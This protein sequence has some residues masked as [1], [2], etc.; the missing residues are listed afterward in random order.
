MRVG[1]DQ[2]HRRLA[3]STLE[4]SLTGI[5]KPLYTVIINRL[6][7]QYHCKLSDCIDHPEYLNEILQ[8]LYGNARKAIVDSINKELS[9]ATEDREVERFLTV[10]NN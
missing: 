1:K 10:I 5:G 3:I 7:N 4:K 2:A 8:D 6:Q 9:N